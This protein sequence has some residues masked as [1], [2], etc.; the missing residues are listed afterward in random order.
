MN[1]P[2]RRTRAPVKR[3]NAQDYLL[4]SVVSFAGSVVITRLFLGLTGYPQLGGGDLHIAHVLWGGLLLFAAAVLPLI[5][6][7]RWVYVLSAA[8][9]GLGV[10]LFIDEVGK[11]ITQ[12][13]DYFSPVAAPIIYAFFLITVLL[14]LQVRRPPSQNPRAELYRVFEMLQDLLDHDL[15]EQERDELEARLRLVAER[16]NSP[17]LARLATALRDVLVSGTLY[18]APVTPAIW[19]IWLNRARAFEARWIGPRRLKTILVAGLGVF[20]FVALA[21]PILVLFRAFSP[22]QLEAVASQWVTG[23]QVRSAVSLQWFFVGL[24]LQG[25]V[26]LLLL[27]G[28]ILLLTGK[29]RR[30]VQLGYFGLLLSLTSVNLLTFYFAQFG[31][32]ALAIVQFGFLLALLH[33]RRRYL[34]LPPI[35]RVARTLQLG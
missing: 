4:I 5:F 33:Y 8:L 23:G 16:G 35:E 11:F 2:V 21:E 34:A 29:E 3:R 27:A 25:L 24:A 18:L 6:A 1:S 19:E 14:Y 20:G 17:D 26:G 22:E 28:S 9:N 10:G 32:L 7:N 30:G 15:D 12:N 31:N 13:N